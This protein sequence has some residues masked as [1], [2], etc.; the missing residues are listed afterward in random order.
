[1]I[2]VCILVTDHI[3]VSEILIPVSERASIY[4]FPNDV[5]P[6]QVDIV[7]EA[8]LGVRITVFADDV[9]RYAPLR[10]FGTACDGDNCIYYR[11]TCD[12]TAMRCDFGE[13][14]PFAERDSGR[15]RF[16]PERFSIEYRT[17]QALQAAQANVYLIAGPKENPSYIP[18]RELDTSATDPTAV[19]GANSTEPGC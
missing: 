4:R 3:C 6:A 14:Q 2:P 13:G 7:A 19:C 9:I 12:D 16:I 18:L 11:K 1:M 8:A 17:R 15:Q 5:V 10:K